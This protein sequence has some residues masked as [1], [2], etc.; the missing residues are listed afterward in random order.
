MGD[1]GRRCHKLE[2]VWF[3]PRSRAVGGKED[4]VGVANA[5]R[6]SAGELLFDTVR[7]QR[8]SKFRKWKSPPISRYQTSSGWIFSP[9]LSSSSIRTAA[10]SWSMRRRWRSEEHT[11]ELQSLG[12][13]DA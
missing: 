5:A 3:D 7:L 12:I 6:K 9:M 8:G 4:G 13:S 1:S 11:S 10:Y 2:H